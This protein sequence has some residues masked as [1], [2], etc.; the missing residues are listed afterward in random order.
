M[1]S[2]E[3]VAAWAADRVFASTGPGIIFVRTIDKCHA[4]A[5]AISEITGKT[6]PPVTSKMPRAQR[7]AIAKQLDAQDAT[8]PLVV[9]TSAWATG[10][11]IPGLCWIAYA[12]RMKAPIFTI[13]AAGRGSRIADGKQD[14]DIY[15]LQGDETSRDREQHTSSL[16]SDA[17]LVEKLSRSREDIAPP[18]ERRVVQVQQHQPARR[19]AARV[20]QKES[21]FDAEGIGAL[22]SFIIISVIV[23]GPFCCS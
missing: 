20:A 8:V 22:I 17:D 23:F 13:Q 5:Q 4:L 21:P 3:K 2:I 7:E 6:V 12:D 9:A 1:A 15:D 14:F 19:R 18:A 10:I 16:C 11:D